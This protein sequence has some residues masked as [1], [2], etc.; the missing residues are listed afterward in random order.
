LVLVLVTVGVT[1]TGATAAEMP[2]FTIE[3]VT[4]KTS[5]TGAWITELFNGE[6]GLR[7]IPAAAAGFEIKIN[8][9]FA[10]KTALVTGKIYAGI[11]AIGKTPTYNATNGTWYVT[12]STPYFE[13]NNTYTIKAKDEEDD[14]VTVN[15]TSV[16][17]TRK[18]LKIAGN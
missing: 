8:G 2:A 3:S 13:S 15:Q 4:Y 5:E 6:G 16:P 1:T 7:T 14:Q 12:Y 9:T 18:K 17:V 10:P 11:T